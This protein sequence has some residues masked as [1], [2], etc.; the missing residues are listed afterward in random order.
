METTPSNVLVDP[1]RRLVA[2][3][4][5]PWP[6]FWEES[7]EMKH[8]KRMAPVLI[9]AL[10]GLTGCSKIAT[11]E[12]TVKLNGDLVETGVVTAYNDKG[13]VLGIGNIVDGG[14]Y[15]IPDLPVGGP[16]ILCVI[17]YGPDGKPRGI[18]AE[19]PGRKENPRPQKDDDKKEHKKEKEL[20]KLPEAVRLAREKIKAVPSKYGSKD[21]SDL[22]VTIGRGKNVYDIEMTG[23][24]VKPNDRS[25]HHR[26]DMNGRQA[27]PTRPGE[28]VPRDP[29]LPPPMTPVKDKQPGGPP[30]RPQ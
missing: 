7:D 11:L 21:S 14:T 13:E 24:G 22:K 26:P 15:S 3:A 25:E 5:S 16:Y 19:E 30:P 28:V 23:E 29:S 6:L 17:T 10:L 27:P 9:V 1:R 2:C 12:G 18:G 20:E 8:I 4:A